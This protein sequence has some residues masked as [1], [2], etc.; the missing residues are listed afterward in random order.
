MRFSPDGKLLYFFGDDV[1]I[2][3]TDN[4]TQVDKWELSPPIEDG[5]GRVDVRLVDDLNDEPG[6]YTGL[7]NG[8]TR[9]RTAASWASAASTC[10]RKTI[11]FY[12]LGPAEAGQL[13]AWRP[14]AS[15]GLRHVPGHRALRVLGLRP[16]ANA[17]SS[18]ARSS[19]A[20]RASSCVT[21]SNGKVLYIYIAGAT[22]DVYDAATYK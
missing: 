1:L 16:R 8:R 11:D 6:F 13:R 10:A 15:V 3:E 22:I 19:R 21:S 7:F 14:T 2:Y 4:F 12:P 9:C 18:A 17:S 5:L 20:A